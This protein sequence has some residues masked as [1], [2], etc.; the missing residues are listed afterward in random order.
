MNGPILN[1]QQM[2]NFDNSESDYS[3]SN[4]ISEMNESKLTEDEHNNTP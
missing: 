4:K 1:L 2:I 3:E